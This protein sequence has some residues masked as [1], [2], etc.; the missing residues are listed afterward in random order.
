MANTPTLRVVLNGDVA[1]AEREAANAMAAQEGISL[2]LMLRR[3]LREKYQTRRRFNPKLFA[4]I[5]PGGDMRSKGKSKKKGV[6]T[7]E[8]SSEQLGDTDGHTLP[9]FR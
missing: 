2:S 3:W 8:Q 5:A 7:D 9:R 4:D 6:K 1:D